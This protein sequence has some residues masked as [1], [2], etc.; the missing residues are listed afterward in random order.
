MAKRKTDEEANRNKTGPSRNQGKERKA[1]KQ[2]IGK[3]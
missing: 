3:K 2:Q 1:V